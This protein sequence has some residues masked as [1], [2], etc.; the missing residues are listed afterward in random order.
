LGDTIWLE[1]TDGK[2]KSGG[3]RDNSIILRLSPQ[4]DALATRLGVEKPS[5][6]HDLGGLGAI[7]GL[8]SKG[9]WFDAQQGHHTFSALLSELRDR[10]ASLAFAPEPSQ[11]HWLEMLMSELEYCVSG[12]R[13]AS[14]QGRKF[15]LRLVS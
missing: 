3:D 8:R 6:F 14:A 4:L 10:P 9:T 13:E 11:R 5:A 12:L 7:V 2:R 15:R 1:T